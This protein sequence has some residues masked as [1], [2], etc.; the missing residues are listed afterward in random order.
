MPLTSVPDPLSPHLAPGLCTQT[1]R[2]RVSLEDRLRGRQHSQHCC[3]VSLIGVARTVQ[4][5]SQP[6]LLLLRQ[7]QTEVLTSTEATAVA[8]V[9][10]KLQAVVV[11]LTQSYLNVK[12]L[13]LKREYKLLLSVTSLWCLLATLTSN[14]TTHRALATRARAMLL[15]HMLPAAKCSAD[16][17]TKQEEQDKKVCS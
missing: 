16:L 8:L 4:N 6:L 3:K 15:E 1:L 7:A 10:T 11:G 14:N 17:T 9:A 12:P 13:R 5:L 2:R